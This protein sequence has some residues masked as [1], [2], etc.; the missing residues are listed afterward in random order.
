MNKLGMSDR[1]HRIIGF[2]QA[3]L[4]GVAGIS[5]VNDTISKDALAY[6]ALAAAVLTLINGSWR[7]LYPEQNP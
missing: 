1:V 7:I 2:A 5:G 6:I 3:I 4:I